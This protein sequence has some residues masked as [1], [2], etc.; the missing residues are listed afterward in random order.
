MATWDTASKIALFVLQYGYMRFVGRRRY[1]AQQ[2]AA[3]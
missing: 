3:A 1:L 2:T